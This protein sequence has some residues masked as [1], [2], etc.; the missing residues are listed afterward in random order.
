MACE[1]PVRAG[2]DKDDAISWKRSAQ[3]RHRRGGM[4]RFRRLLAFSR[5]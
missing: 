3:S 2:I 1:G 4:D 5:S